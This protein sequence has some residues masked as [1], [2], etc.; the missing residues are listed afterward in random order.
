[1][2]IDHLIKAVKKL[3]KEL[4]K[5]NKEYLIFNKSSVS[6]EEY[7]RKKLELQSY[8]K[9]LWITLSDIPI[10]SGLRDD[11]HKIVYE[12]D[13]KSVLHN[14]GAPPQKGFAKV[15]HIEPMYS[16]S[17]SFSKSEL[18]EWINRCETIVRRVERTQNKAVKES[19]N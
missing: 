4:I 9:E 11:Y 12:L 3:E 7:D 6:D 18:I 13:I 15:K 5:Y 14:V 17:N 19:T 16:L 10:T 8:Y 2:S 1:M